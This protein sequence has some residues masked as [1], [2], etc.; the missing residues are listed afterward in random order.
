MSSSTVTS[1]NSKHST[2]P[3][4]I[5]NL[6]AY[7]PPPDPYGKSKRA[8]VLVGLVIDPDT[9]RLDVWLTLRSSKLRK[10]AGEVSLPGG[11]YEVSDLDLITTALRE[12]EEEIGL[13]R[14]HVDCVGCLPPFP[15]RFLLMVTPVVGIIPSWFLP[16]DISLDEVAACFKVPLEQFLREENHSSSD[17]PFLDHPYRIHFF[18]W[19]TGDQTYRIWGLTAEILIR[20]ATIAYGREPDFGVMADRQPSTARLLETLAEQGHFEPKL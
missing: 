16:T 1:S 4:E 2:L 13:D 9:Q 6:L 11:R 15:S 7:T 17:G 8:A 12:T 20:A 10:H 14:N 19:T 3:V 18:D 5:E